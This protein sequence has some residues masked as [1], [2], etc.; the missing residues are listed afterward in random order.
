MVGLSLGGYL[1]ARA[2]A[3]DD[4]IDGVVSYDVFFD[5]SAVA[6]RRL[7]A[8]A[9]ALRRASLGRLPAKRPLPRPA[10]Q[11]RWTRTG[12]SL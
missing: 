2:A 11:P 10:A 3:F 7:P 5:G 1:A 8:A 6:A 12:S 4:R 9:R